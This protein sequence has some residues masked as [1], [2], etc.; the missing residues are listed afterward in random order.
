MATKYMTTGHF[1]LR[2]AWSLHIEMGLG[3]AAVFKWLVSNGRWTI[4]KQTQS[5]HSS[6]GWKRLTAQGGNWGLWETAEP[7]AWVHFAYLYTGYFSWA[8][9][10]VSC[11]QNHIQANVKVTSCSNCSLIYQRSKNAISIFKTRD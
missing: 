9:L 3:R 6:C 1:T 10:S 5:S 7:C 8:L 4:G 11:R 2:K